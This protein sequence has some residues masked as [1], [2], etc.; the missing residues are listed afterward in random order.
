MTT[1]AT[2]TEETMTKRHDKIRDLIRS[3][4]PEA[5]TLYVDRQQGRVACG[6]H[7]GGYLM[8]A[9]TEGAFSESRGYNPNVGVLTALDVWVLVTDEDQTDGWVFACETCNPPWGQS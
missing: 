1:A 4:D 3:Q 7:G 8:A 6:V 9:I 2:T 5:R